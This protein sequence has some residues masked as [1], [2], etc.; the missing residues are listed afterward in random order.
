V[1]LPADTLGGRLMAMLRGRPASIE[2]RTLDRLRKALESARGAWGNAGG[3][4]SFRVYRTAAGLRVLETARV[5]EP[6]SPPVLELM[7]AAGTDR[8]FVT[9]CGVQKCFRARLTP[10]PWRIEQPKPPTSFPFASAADEARMRRWQQAYEA[11][12]SGFAVCRLI[13]QIGTPRVHAD[14]ARTLETHDRLTRATADL[15]LA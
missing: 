2:A 9:L 15:P 7:R 4:A 6:G 10:K 3:D 8:A 1:D 12:S 11:A 13:E 5:H 14:L